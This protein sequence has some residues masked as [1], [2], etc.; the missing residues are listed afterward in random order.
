M[1]NICTIA[2]SFSSIRHLP[3]TDRVMANKCHLLEHFPW[4]QQCR[5]FFPS[6]FNIRVSFPTKDKASTDD[7]FSWWKRFFF[8]RSS[9]NKGAPTRNETENEAKV[10]Y[11]SFP[12]DIRS[13]TLNESA[14]SN[15]KEIAGCQWVLHMKTKNFSIAVFR[16]VRVRHEWEKNDASFFFPPSS[17]KKTKE[18]S[19]APSELI[20]DK[21]RKCG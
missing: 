20:K 18:T 11:F 10:L 13:V 6:S 21:R 15:K 8:R 19:E 7:S 12:P 17:I 3:K 2:S 1:C 4:R 16:S 14:D 9:P 5:I